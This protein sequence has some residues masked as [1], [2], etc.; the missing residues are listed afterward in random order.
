[1]D[2][3]A[4]VRSSDCERQDLLAHLEGVG[5]KAAKFAEKLNVPDAGRIL[6]L[7]HDFGKYSRSFQNYINSA[8]G[9]LDPDRDGGYVDAKGM[10]GK[11]DHSSAGAQWIWGKLREKDRQGEGELCGQILALCIASH[12]SG[13][14]NILDP[15]NKPR[16]QMRMDKPDEKT[17]LKECIENSSNEYKQRISNI[18]ESN[19]IK[20]MWISLCGAING[21]GVVRSDKIKAFYMGFWARFL[22]S[23]LVDADR[24]DSADF[25]EPH[26]ENLR[27]KKPKW[28]IA[29]KRFEN[30]LSKIK[31]KNKVDDIRKEISDQ[32]LKRATEKQGLYNLTVPTGGGKTFASLRYALHHAEKH[33]LERIIYIV[34]FTSII[35]QNA[36][37]VRKILDRE[38]DKHPWVLEIHSNLEPELQNWKTKLLSEN[39]DAPIIFTTMVQF[40]EALFGGGTRSVR[41]LHQLANSVIIFDEIQS[42]PIK[43]VHIFCNALN[44][45]SQNTRTTALLCT[46]TQPLLHKLENSENGQLNLSP[47]NELVPNLQKTFDDLNRVRIINRTCSQGWTAEQIAE[48]AV[49][50]VNEKGNC[51]IIVNTKKWARD[52]Y[53]RCCELMD[54]DQVFHLSTNLYPH[55]RKS[56][57]EEVKNRISSQQSKPT[58]CISTQ[59][60][61]SGVDID[62]A[63]VIRFLAGIDSIAQAAGRCNR[64]GVRKYGTVHIVN[65]DQEN[66][67]KLTEIKIG[68]DVARRVLD[69]NEST[70]ILTPEIMDIYFEYYFFNRKDRMSYPLT[71]KQAKRTDSLLNL[72]SENEH[73][74]LS[75]S[76]ENR[77]PLLQ[78]SFMTAGKAFEVIDA[79]TKSIIVQHGKGKK[80][81]TKLCASFRPN[82]QRKLLRKA[83]MY[84]VNVFPNVW[85]NLLDE[86]AIHPVQEDVEIY[87][88][89]KEHYHEKFGMSVE[90]V[91]PPDPGVY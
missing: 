64:N 32:C 41:R 62:F 52:I 14:I 5:E 56:I 42:L 53:Q 3:T 31:R 88:L 2:F 54:E 61:E 26:K 34:P 79:P 45:L 81:V 66:I 74:G 16:F 48:L 15:E 65:P 33:K 57:I 55:H 50:E 49:Q 89:K 80:I 17:H 69:E 47:E 87:Y 36:D 60:I 1:M 84:S 73:N 58:L 83:Q 35:E 9:F 24:I 91:R 51:L 85:Q 78:Q 63:S 8:T 40:L 75:G 19:L 13:L 11:I 7:L 59:L 27:H 28:S 77:I 37:E 21:D 76:N 4:H 44:F 68:I 10:K 25:E 43:C 67:E 70:N 12:H 90:S 71:A 6:G 86:Q 22:F 72:L 30:Y 46:A 20:Q 29:I 82:S 18:A 38:N 23:C 39:W